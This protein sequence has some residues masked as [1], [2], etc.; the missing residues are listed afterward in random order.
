MI[1]GLITVL[2]SRLEQGAVVTFIYSNRAYCITP[3]IDYPHTDSAGWPGLSEV[4]LHIVHSDII[5]YIVYAC[6]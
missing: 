4:Y 1:I 5:L 2:Y 3:R 6:S